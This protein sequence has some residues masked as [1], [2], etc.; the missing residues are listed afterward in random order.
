MAMFAGRELR[1]SSASTMPTQAWA[2]GAEYLYAKYSSP[3][4]IFGAGGERLLCSALWRRGL[5][6]TSLSRALDKKA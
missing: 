3:G 1:F 5:S 4:G 6:D 2:P